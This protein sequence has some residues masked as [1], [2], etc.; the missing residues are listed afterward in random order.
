MKTG[1]K[2]KVQAISRPNE[3]APGSVLILSESGKSIAVAFEDGMPMSRDSGMFIHTQRP[4]AM[5]L[6]AIQIEDEG[7]WSDIV[8]GEEYWITEEPQP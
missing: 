4:H 7:T 8:T 3:A 6:M 2:V 5:V 1:D